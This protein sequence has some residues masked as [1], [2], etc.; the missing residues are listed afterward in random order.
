MA[1]RYGWKPVLILEA[2]SSGDQVYDELKSEFSIIRVDPTTEKMQ[3]LSTCS[4]LIEAHQVSLPSNATGI[5]I[6]TK[7]AKAPHCAKDDVDALSQFLNWRRTHDGSL[8]GWKAYAE[9]MRTGRYADGSPVGGPPPIKAES[10]G[11]SIADL[12]RAANEAAGLSP[13]PATFTP[14]EP[15]ANQ[16]GKVAACPTCGNIN[17]FESSRGQKC[18]ACGWLREF[19]G[20][21]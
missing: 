19:P 18:M 8:A 6:Q 20:S 10:P 7:T 13:R 1:E 9:L 5:D 2:K 3:R 14:R 17:L 16:R 21:L 11:S 15:Q 4:P 12:H